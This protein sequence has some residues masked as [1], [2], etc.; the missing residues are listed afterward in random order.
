M[1]KEI[2]YTIEEDVAI[3]IKKVTGKISDTDF[4]GTYGLNENEIEMIHKFFYLVQ[5]K[6]E[7]E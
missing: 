6:D 2:K 7:E 5:D 1:D 3:A 4:T